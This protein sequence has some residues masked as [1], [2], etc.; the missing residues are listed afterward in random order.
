[1]P[2]EIEAVQWFKPGDHPK[3]KSGAGPATWPDGS[4]KVAGAD[5]GFIETLEGGHIVTPGD[6]I[7]Q[8]VNGEFYPCKP[9]IFAKTYE[10]VEPSHV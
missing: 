3:V 4:I 8:G 1:M 9:D 2:V 6:W 7:I 10:P 5:C